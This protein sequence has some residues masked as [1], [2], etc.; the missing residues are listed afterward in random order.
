M[1]PDRSP[2]VDKWGGRTYVGADGVARIIAGVHR[3]AIG[4]ALSARPV[5]VVPSLSSASKTK[6]TSRGYVVEIQAGIFIITAA[7][8]DQDRRS[9]YHH[10]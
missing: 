4:V 10:G 7:M 5:P 9:G 3:F 6:P 2:A 1:Y 8:E